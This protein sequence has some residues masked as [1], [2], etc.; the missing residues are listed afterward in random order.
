MKRYP[1]LILAYI[2]LNIQ[3][4]YAQQSRTT[5]NLDS[6]VSQLGE[7]AMKMPQATGLSIG[8][9][10]EGKDHFYNFGSVEK[11][12]VVSPGKNTLYEIGSVA[13][14]FTSFLLAKAIIE[15]KISLDDDIRKY[16]SDS[17]PRL[18]Y[19][20]HFIKVMHLANATSGLPD[21]LPPTPDIIK[22]APPDSVG[23]LRARI[24]GG[25]TRK[26]FYDALKEV[27]P[28]TIP[29][30]VRRHSNAGADLLTYI[31]EAVYKKPY[32]E[33]VEQ[34]IFKPLKMKSSVFAVDSKTSNLA[35]GYN[36]NGLAMPYSSSAVSSTTADLLKYIKLHLKGENK[37][38]KL[39]LTKTADIDLSNNKVV[40][41][42]TGVNH[43]ALNWFSF[44]NDN[45]TSQTW[46]DG[47]T[48][49]F[50]SYVVF[51]PEVKVAIV[52]LANVADEKTYRMLPGIA[53]E[54]FKT[55]GPAAK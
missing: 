50:M 33:L 30:S 5:I 15:K 51:Y 3:F 20:G 42:S 23:F 32:R 16:L 35:K 52:L 37:Y 24:Y 8:V 31:L 12:K 21:W 22:N 1:F 54:I 28:D 17:F 55:I 44:K 19:N 6:L 40:Q 48:H 29:G 27:K 53:Y 14:T 34:Y 49:G 36:G 7:K 9:Y 11:G 46:Y 45:G 10:Y 47:G 41:R 2:L 26:D 18:E 39:A 43:T 25:Y 38:A 4:V 13:K